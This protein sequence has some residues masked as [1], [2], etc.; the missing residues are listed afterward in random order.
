[1]K[2]IEIDGQIAGSVFED[3]DIRCCVLGN[4]RPADLDASRP[5]QTESVLQRM[6]LALMAA[7]MRLTDIVRTWFFIDRILDWYGGFNAVRSRFFRDRNLFAGVLPASTGVGTANS[8]GAALIADVLAMQSK[9]GQLDFRD[10]VSPLQC[11]AMDYRSSFS[12]AV[13]VSMAGQRSLFIS[14]T[15][16]IAPDG[17]T[18]H[19]GDVEKQV[20]LTM[21]VVEKMLQSRRMSWSNVTRGIAYFKDID[22]AAALER[23]C[24]DNRILDLP[25]VVS[26]ADICRDDLLFEIE[27]DAASGTETSLE[28]CP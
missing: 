8:A 22:E 12:R 23:Y 19:V 10:V 27:L 14:G 18:A 11:P 26:A 24:R 17:V 4:L 20:D 6:E 5:D 1:V 7:D 25:V 15:A 13:E 28:P 21:T 16:S 3:D 2:P 9:R